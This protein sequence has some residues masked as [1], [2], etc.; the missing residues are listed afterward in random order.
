MNYDNWKL[1]SPNYSDEVS[2][3]CGAGYE[4]T[5]D[6]IYETNYICDKCKDACDIQDEKEYE[7]D[8]WESYQEDLADDRRH[9]L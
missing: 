2:T 9:G 1:S 5:D 7:Q 6:E 8:R 3:C 4:E